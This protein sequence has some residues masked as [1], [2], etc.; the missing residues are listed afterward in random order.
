MPALEEA[1]GMAKA[2]ESTELPY[3]I[4]YMIRDN[5]KLIDGISIHTAIETIDNNTLRK[6]LC[7]MVNCVHPRI[8]KTA[9]SQSFNLSNIVRERFSGIQ[10]NTSFLSPE[11][12]DNCE[13]LETSDSVSLADEMID[14]FNYFNPKIFGGCCGTNKSHIEEIAKKLKNIEYTPH[15]K[16]S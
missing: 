4:S 11:E 6:P 2:M 12:L 9:L 13:D 15:N 5:G 3:I 14:L 1:I 16:R 8:L 7:Y 10:A